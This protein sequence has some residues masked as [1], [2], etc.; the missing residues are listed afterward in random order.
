MTAPTNA[1]SV[2]TRL[3]LNRRSRLARVPT[4]PEGLLSK[5]KNLRGAMP[6]H[7]YTQKKPDTAGKAAL[8]LTV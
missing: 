3:E 1:V 6:R 2:P 4:L 5:P 7:L 8:Y